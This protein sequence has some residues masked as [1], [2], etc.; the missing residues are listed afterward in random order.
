MVR[1]IRCCSTALAEW[2]RD[3]TGK[4]K[5]RIAGC[6]K[7]LRSLRSRRDAGSVA[8]YKEV[9]AK[10]FEILTQKELYWK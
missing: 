5:E 3:I 8:R 4:F 1:K 7:V 2:G 9:Q 10:L 6:N